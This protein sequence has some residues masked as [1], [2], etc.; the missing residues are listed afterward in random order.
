MNKYTPGDKKNIL[1]LGGAGFIG[2]FLCEELVKDQNVICLDNFITSNVENIRLLIQFPNFEFIKHDICQS[3]NLENLPEL[4]K[5]KINIHGIQEIYNL[6]CPTVQKDYKKFSIET[7]LTNSLGVKNSL[8]LAIQYQ[9]KYLFGSSSSVYGDCRDQVIK[10]DIICPLDF[11]GPRS[12]YNEGKRFAEMMIK[13]YGEFYNLETKIARIFSTYGPRMIYKDARLIPDFIDQALNNQT[14]EIEGDE[15][16]LINYVYVQDLVEGLIKLMKYEGSLIVN[17]SGEQEFYLK[18]II[19][20][21]IKI[22]NSQSKI[23]FIKPP[24]YLTRIVKSD[25]TLAKE[26]LG[27][28]PLIKLE[29][30]L[31]RTIDYLKASK[32]LGVQSVK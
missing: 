28:L 16:T 20:L 12:A 29:E 24:E 14:I 1:V 10:E 22:T 15:K 25:I 23:N 21:I 13:K 9:A 31:R 32:Y 7:I 17:L 2:S 27:W 18:D 6:A 11:H 26:R 4:K 8:D 3:I 30:G 5:F 19:E